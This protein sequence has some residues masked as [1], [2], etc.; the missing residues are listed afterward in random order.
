MISG[1]SSPPWL[2]RSRQFSRRIA[3]EGAASAVE[4]VLVVPLLLVILVGVVDLGRIG[5]INVSLKAA[6]HEG[7]RFSA[8]HP[9]GTGSDSA[10]ITKINSL[11][12]SVASDAGDIAGSPLAI[13]A[14]VTCS[15]NPNVADENTSVTIS[16]TFTW[17]L[18]VGLVDLVSAGTTN[19]SSF[20]ISSTG[21]ARCLG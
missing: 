1:W 11:L 17:F 20:Q 2:V 15:S 3:S 12:T 18:P 21:V 16:T 10:L 13:P 8:L 5:L 7:A 6:S 19:L 9:R 14:P 4:F